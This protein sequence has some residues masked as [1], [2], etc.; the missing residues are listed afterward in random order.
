MSQCTP[1]TTIK[2]AMSEIHIWRK[3][4]S[5][6]K[7]HDWKLSPSGVMKQHSFQIPSLIWK[8]KIGDLESVRQLHSDKSEF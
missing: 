2:K 1:S 5:K 8:L 4:A 6:Q 3:T 7:A